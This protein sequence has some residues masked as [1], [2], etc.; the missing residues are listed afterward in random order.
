MTYSQVYMYHR[1]LFIVLAVS[2]IFLL[3]FGLTALGGA[4]LLIGLILFFGLGIPHG[5]LDVALG[6]SLYKPI[7]G[8]FWWLFFLIS[9]LR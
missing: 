5:A 9:Y 1:F 4:E 6:R 2:V 3:P 7:F 8:K